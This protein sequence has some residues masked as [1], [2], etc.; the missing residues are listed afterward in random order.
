MYARLSQAEHCRTGHRLV[1]FIFRGAMTLS[2]PFRPRGL[3]LFIEHQIPV[4][5]C[6]FKRLLVRV[7]LELAVR[8][9][10]SNRTTD[11]EAEPVTE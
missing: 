4:E 7:L 6:H 1:F 11:G 3:L 9:G 2:V 8:G 5:S 10:N